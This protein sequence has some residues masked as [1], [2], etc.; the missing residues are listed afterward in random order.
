MN[1]FP[2]SFKMLADGVFFRRFVAPH[3]QV[4]SD[5]TVG[6]IVGHKC[7]HFVQVLFS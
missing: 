4:V 1:L 7:T 5:L 2:S 6:L 3:L